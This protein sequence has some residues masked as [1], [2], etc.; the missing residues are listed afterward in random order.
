MKKVVC[1]ILAAALVFGLSLN[2]LAAERTDCIVS[3][4]SLPAAAG[5][6]VTVP[7]RISG[8]PGFT[9][10]GIALDY[11]REQL[12][13]LSIQTAEGETPYLCGPAVSVNPDWKGADEKTYGYVTAA[14]ADPIPGDGILFTATFRVSG[15][16]SGAAAVTPVIQY[17]RSN[18]SLFPVFDAIKA[19]AEAG[20]LSSVLTGDY[21]RN[22]IVNVIDV[23]GLYNAIGNGDGFTEADMAR[24]DINQDGTVNAMDVMGIYRIVM[25]G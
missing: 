2:A 16:F 4:D 21:D 23:M 20:T 25:G 3:A 9:N 1:C 19:E 14:S 22:G 24:L 5:E 6:T 17:L 11:D 8:N 7:I 10:F 15:G 12:E 18:Q 13:L